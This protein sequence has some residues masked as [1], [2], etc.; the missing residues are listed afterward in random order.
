MSFPFNEKREH[1][2]IIG[3]SFAGGCQYHSVNYNFKPRSIDFEKEGILETNDA[4]CTIRF[5][6][7]DVK[8]AGTV[9]EGN[10][11][12]QE[13]E[14]ILIIDRQ[15][16]TITLERVTSRFQMRNNRMGDDKTQ[17]PPRRTLN[18]P[19][20]RVSS[21]PDRNSNRGR[22]D[23][24]RARHHHESSS[25]SSLPHKPIKQEPIKQE[26][27]IKQEPIKM[28]PIKQ[29]PAELILPSIIGLGADIS[30]GTTTAPRKPRLDS[31]FKSPNS[32]SD[33]NQTE[34][35]SSSSS[36][37]E[38]DEDDRSSSAAT[39]PAGAGPVNTDYKNLGIDLSDS[40]SSD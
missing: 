22:D 3:D 19:S 37:E 27:H 6:T 35:D 28:E 18:R 2:L 30:T 10:R 32:E 34:S 15:T 13:K 16:N 12:K 11:Q 1:K 25:S 5:P 21:S 29:E 23:A 24:K 20:H 33:Q 40:D 8:K 4:K 7:A 31:L 17:F 14:C 38:S 9:Y 26:P 39:T 36:S